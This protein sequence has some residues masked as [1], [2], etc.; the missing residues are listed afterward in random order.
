[1]KSTPTIDA[2]TGANY[3][4]IYTNTGSTNIDGSLTI[5][6]SHKRAVLWYSGS[7]SSKTPGDAN[8]WITNNASAKIAFDA[9]L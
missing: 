3:Y 9:E 7:D 8:R 4:L 1:M 5:F 2:N 6:K